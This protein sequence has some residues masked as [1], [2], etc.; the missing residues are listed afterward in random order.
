MSVVVESNELFGERV[1]F[2]VFSIAFCLD[3][4]FFV[5]MFDEYKKC[6]ILVRGTVVII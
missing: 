1:R 4:A 6:D 5:F 3:A 2:G